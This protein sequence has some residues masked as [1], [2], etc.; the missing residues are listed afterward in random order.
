MNNVG[1]AIIQRTPILSQISVAGSIIII[2]DKVGK[3]K[4]IIESIRV[5]IRHRNQTFIK[6]GCSSKIIL[7]SSFV[8]DLCQNHSAKE[9]KT[10]GDVV[11][12]IDEETGIVL[13]LPN[14]QPVIEEGPFTTV[15]LNKLCLTSSILVDV[16][17]V[18]VV[19]RTKRVLLP[20]K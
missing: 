11:D 20:E 19:E 13:K 8:F 14:D 2:V 18:N 3:F 9:S 7:I 4:V 15:Q 12:A 6:F 5:N 16:I 10:D 1:S 17:V